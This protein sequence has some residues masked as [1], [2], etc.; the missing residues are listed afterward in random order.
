MWFFYALSK[1]PL[2]VLYGISGVLYFFLRHV[3]KYRLSVVRRNISLSFPNKGESEV[4]TIINSFYRSMS[5][6]IVETI[7]LLSMSEK[8]LNRRVSVKNE[9]ALLKHFD[10]G[11]SVLLTACHQFNW[12]WM[13]AAG[14]TH[15]GY[16]FDPAYRPIKN[17]FFNNLIITIRSRFGGKTIVDKDLKRVLKENERVVG[18]SIVMDHVS[19]KP[20]AWRSFLNQDTLF[21]NSIKTLA[22]LSGLP[23]VYPKLKKIKRG[24]YEIELIPLAEPPYHPDHNFLDRF[25]KEIEQSI[26]DQ[27]E[28][29]M[30]THR[31]WK[32]SHQPTGV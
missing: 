1:L 22:E 9:E 24:Y 14:R 7:K 32:Y 6:M 11:T 26:N 17:K 23:V 10:R 13:V 25:I 29:Y 3:A 12:E 16:S 20:F 27:P 31:R 5:D 18:F 2:V 15:L 8:E 28:T 19:G 30:W 4:S 21:D